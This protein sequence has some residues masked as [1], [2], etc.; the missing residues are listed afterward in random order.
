MIRMRGK[1]MGDMKLYIRV[2]MMAFGGEGLKM[3]K[4]R[5]GI[6]MEFYSMRESGNVESLMG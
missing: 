2:Y 5:F 1:A 6:K 3:D 4:A